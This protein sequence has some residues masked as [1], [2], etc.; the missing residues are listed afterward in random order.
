METGRNGEREDCK[1]AVSVVACAAARWCEQPTVYR[2][3]KSCAAVQGGRYI[4][5]ATSELLSSPDIT[6]SAEICCFLRVDKMM[7]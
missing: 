6:A 5:G 4:K 7:S 2:R 1:A 3:R